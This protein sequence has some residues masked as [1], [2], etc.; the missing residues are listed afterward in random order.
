MALIATAAC[1]PWFRRWNSNLTRN[2]VVR[3]VLVGSALSGCAGYAPAH[4][5]QTAVKDAGDDSRRVM[6]HARDILYKTETSKFL[7]S[8]PPRGMVFPGRDALSCP[9]AM[10]SQF[11]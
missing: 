1:S 7:E 3:K 8:Y 4:L 9:F 2:D 10:S 11:L 6:Q 5:V